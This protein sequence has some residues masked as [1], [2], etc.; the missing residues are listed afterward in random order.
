MHTPENPYSAGNEGMTK[1]EWFAGQALAG[2]CANPDLSQQAAA[3][4]LT[5]AQCRTAWVDGAADLADALIADLEKSGKEGV[6]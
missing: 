1:R 3:R 2:I 6:K 5:P 4:G